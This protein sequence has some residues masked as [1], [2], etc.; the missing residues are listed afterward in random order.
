MK[1]FKFLVSSQSYFLRVFCPQIYFNVHAGMLVNLII[2]T[3]IVNFTC[4]VFSQKSH[5]V[6]DRSTGTATLLIGLLVEFD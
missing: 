1:S 4:V 5:S 6:S 3:P 2:G